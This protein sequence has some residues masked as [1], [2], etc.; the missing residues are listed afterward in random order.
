MEKSL[1]LRRQNAYQLIDSKD[2]SLKIFNTYIIALAAFLYDIDWKGACYAISSILYVL[3]TEQ[4]IEVD[5]YIGEV[6]YQNNYFDH[7]WVEINQDIYDISVANPLAQNADTIV[8]PVFKGIDLDTM[9]PTL[10]TY[11]VAS[12]F[13]DDEYARLIK[14]S[15]L[16]QYMDKPVPPL[17]GMTLWDMAIELGKLLKL[18]L[19]MDVVKSKYLKTQW[20]EKS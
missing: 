3:Y 15:T 12:E 19:N 5:L 7:S 11:G 2:T 1:E 4:N 18:N 14:N 16:T 13:E 9:K 17:S 6:K 8:G 20:K 10:V